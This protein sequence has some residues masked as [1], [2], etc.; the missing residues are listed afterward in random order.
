MALTLS[1]AAPDFEL[2][3]RAANRAPRTIEKYLDSL[4][5]L[6]RHLESVG[7]SR[8]VRDVTPADVERWM[9]A[10]Q[11]RGN[12]AATVALRFRSIQQFF[13]WCR[14]EDE[15]D[16]DPTEGL[17]VPQV[18]EQ[19]VPVLSD[20]DVAAL[21]AAC[22][23]TGFQEARDT[24]VIRLM[25]DTG[26]RRA[27]L[28][29]L[30][31]DDVDRAAR[32]IRVMGK[33]RRARTIR[34]GVKT[35]EA[36][37][38][39]LRRRAEHQSAD[40]PAL[41]LSARGPGAWGPDGVRAMLERRAAQAGLGH[42]HAHQFRHTFASDYLASGGLEG[43]LMRTAGWSSRQMLSRYGAAVADERARDAR[44]RLELK[45]DRL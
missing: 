26:V 1:S 4:R 30:Q 5:D 27:E 28:L 21:L 3:L 9:V 7:H 15:L 40:L 41:W 22:K 17:T 19:P 44:D 33:G 35:G 29:G 38:R 11:D 6:D 43:D 20:A 23:G 14:R 2:S 34:Y 39:Y 10:Q 31:V 25:L 12:A 32:T 37:G 42:I 24:A 16:V 13:K 36:L 8:R 18:P 45:G